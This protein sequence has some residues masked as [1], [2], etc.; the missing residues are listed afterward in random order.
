LRKK[1]HH[2]SMDIIIEGVLWLEF[3]FVFWLNLLDWCL[4]Q[5]QRIFYPEKIIP[6]P[7]AKM[8]SVP[9]SKAKKGETEV[10]RT[11]PAAENWHGAYPYTDEYLNLDS[12]WKKTVKKY[13]KRPCQGTRK[14]IRK[15]TQK[16]IVNG[17]EK[18]WIVPEYGDIE[19]KTFEQVDQIMRNIMSGLIGMLK[20]KPKDKLG[21][22]EDTREEWIQM[23]H[24]CMK[25]NI[26]AVTV[27]ANLG[28][29]GLITAINETELSVLFLNASAIDNV[30]RHESKMPTL[31]Y[32]IY[33]D[34]YVQPKNDSSNL[35]CISLKDLIEYGAKHP[36]D[37]DQTPTRNDV[38]LIM[39]TS[40]TCG[41]P[42]GCVIK[43]ENMCS[44]LSAITY[45]VRPCL[46]EVLGLEPDD[47][48]LA[49]L[50]LAHIFEIQCEHFMFFA[51]GKVG[52]GTPRTLA[53]SGAKPCG[54]FKAYK[55]TVVVFVP[56]VCDT[57]KKASLEKVA[58][59]SPVLRWLYDIAYKSKLKAFLSG[60][61]TPFWN[62]LVFN[63]F[64]KEVGGRIRLSISGGAALSK[65]THEFMR[66]TYCMRLVQGYGLTETT[67]GSAVQDYYS[68]DFDVVGAPMG[69]CEIKLVNCPELNY[70]VDDKPYPRGE[71]LIRGISI[72]ENYFNQPELDKETW[73]EDGWLR[74]GDIGMF[75][76]KGDLAIIDRKK[77][78][79]K[80]AHGEYV[81]VSYLET[82]YGSSPFVSPNGI[83]VYGDQSQ[84]KLVAIITPQE[85]YI[86][87][88]AKDRKID[89]TNVKNLYNNLLLREAVLESFRQ[90]AKK[91]G[92]R[93]FEYIEKVY[94]CSDI[95]TTENELLTAAMKL[96][97]GRVINQYRDEIDGM[98]T[99]IESNV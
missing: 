76:E 44:L 4:W 9:V 89:G 37:P 40:G 48:Y 41:D 83:L 99:E 92:L 53:D 98:Y 43:H 3:F 19:W 15:H 64:A 20:L 85:S 73:T 97:R 22:F 23:F 6:T 25:N 14:L 29:K 32:L 57:I 75:N 12:M 1:M 87:Q 59:S 77:N 93:K 71:V 58:Q 11:P 78:L 90:I 79:V 45:H 91:N 82:L 65:D 26:T 56:R 17:K 36:V 5:V 7:T 86:E 54:D 39:Y 95:W 34:K 46:S 30:K 52:Y 96:R 62:F 21:L 49:Y 80:M 28:E 33:T 84:M 94:L 51:G 2:N 47:L 10:R 35:I 38:A 88:W 67:S 16:M 42:K 70:Y 68:R 27:Y 18:E 66:I 13:G 69:S 81:P 50:P 63:R 24:G 74:T 55:P 72:I 60:R 31:K 61:D 8:A